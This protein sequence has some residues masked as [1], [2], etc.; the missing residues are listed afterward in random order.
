MCRL[1][2]IPRSAAAAP[3]V[4]VILTLVAAGCSKSIQQ[5]TWPVTGVVEFDGK[6]LAGAT[7]VFHAVDRAKFKWKEL[8]QGFT[9]SEGRFSIRTYTSDDGAPAGDYDVGIAMVQPTSDEGEDQI[10]RVKGSTVI[11]ATYADPK[12]SGI[13]VTVDRKK[14][15]LPTITLAP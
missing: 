10:R 9:D 15:V 14:T 1:P 5:P 13:R 6:P 2:R 7:I 12:T 8:P 4:V 3:V 11:P